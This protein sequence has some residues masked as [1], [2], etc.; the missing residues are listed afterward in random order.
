MAPPRCP[1]TPVTPVSARGDAPPQPARSASAGR[2]SRYP[3][4]WAPGRPRTQL[5]AVPS[6][7]PRRRSQ[8]VHHPS[9]TG[10]LRGCS[11]VCSPAPHTPHQTPVDSWEASV[12]HAGSGRDIPAMWRTASTGG[13]PTSRHCTHPTV[14]GRPML[15]LRRTSVRT[16]ARSC[17]LPGKAA[18]EL[19]QARVADGDRDDPQRH[20]RVM[21]VG[22]PPK[23]SRTLMSQP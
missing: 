19:G 10:A 18:R 20:C 2:T 3:G 17:S 11:R 22:P 6:P 5:R 23:P 1:A 15:R 21:K 13:S 8:V 7:T 16:L 12:K 14:S 9:P 4:P